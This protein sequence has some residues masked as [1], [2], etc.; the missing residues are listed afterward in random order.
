MRK[1]RCEPFIC[2]CPT[3]IGNPANGEDEILTNVW[4]QSSIQHRNVYRLEEH[5]IQWNKNSDRYMNFHFPPFHIYILNSLV[6]EY[7]LKG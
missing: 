7:V 6:Y 5:V 4:K 3:S 1:D 2:W